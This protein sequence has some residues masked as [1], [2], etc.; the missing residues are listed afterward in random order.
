MGS[1]IECEQ[2]SFV[3][4]VVPRRTGSELH[5]G[6]YILAMATPYSFSHDL[7]PQLLLDYL[8]PKVSSWDAILKEQR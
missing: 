2:V 1:S 6:R 8:P 5:A 4:Q 3:L 7:L